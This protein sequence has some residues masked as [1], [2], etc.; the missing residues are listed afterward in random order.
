MG[1]SKSKSKVRN[2][3]KK[4]VRHYRLHF[5]VK[6]RPKGTSLYRPTGPISTEPP[7]TDTNVQPPKTK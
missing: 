3:S 6:C 7:N 5:T 1:K 2:T 4:S